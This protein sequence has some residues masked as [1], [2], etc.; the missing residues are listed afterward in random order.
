MSTKYFTI[1]IANGTVP[2][3]GVENVAY[4]E[5]NNV[6]RMNNRKWRDKEKH[7]II[8][9]EKKRTTRGKHF[10]QRVKEI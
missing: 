3:L 9:K 6:N 4:H 5:N 10:M 1:D 2:L 8:E 7:R